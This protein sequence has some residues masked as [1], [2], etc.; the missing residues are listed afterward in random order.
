M[1]VCYDSIVRHQL[2]FIY[3]KPF[4]GTSCHTTKSCGC[5]ISHGFM[6]RNLKNRIYHILRIL[7]PLSP[8]LAQYHS[9]ICCIYET[10]WNQCITF[11]KQQECQI[12][13]WAE[14]ISEYSATQIWTFSVFTPKTNPPSMF[15]HV[16]SFKITACCEYWDEL[17]EIS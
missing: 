16:Q 12:R 3:S 6:D 5:I 7:G 14:L 15:T 17:L 2:L 11:R 9:N 8:I 10:R 1:F 13:T 4:F